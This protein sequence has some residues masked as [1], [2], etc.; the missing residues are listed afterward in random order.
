MNADPFLTGRIDYILCLL[1]SILYFFGLVLLFAHN[2]SKD[3]Y[4]QE[5]NITIYINSCKMLM[6]ENVLKWKN[7]HYG[8][9]PW[10]KHLIPDYCMPLKNQWIM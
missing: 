3:T 9:E 8:G 5:C 6:C 1:L 10:E 2:H 4:E 7:P